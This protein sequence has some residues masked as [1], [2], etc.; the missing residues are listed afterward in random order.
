MAPGPAAPAPR[1]GHTIK[2]VSIDT[3]NGAASATLVVDG[4]TYASKKVGAV[5]GDRAG[6]RS[7]SS[8]STRLA[9]TVTILHGDVQLTLHVGQTFSK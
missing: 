2:A 9:Q 3:Q 8:A 5:F 7:R 4:T 1:L 6:A